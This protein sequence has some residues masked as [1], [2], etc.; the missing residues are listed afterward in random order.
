MYLFVGFIVV[1]NV[2]K[3]DVEVCLFKF[4][5]KVEVGIYFVWCLVGEFFC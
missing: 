4:G 5:D 3:D 2:I 1:L